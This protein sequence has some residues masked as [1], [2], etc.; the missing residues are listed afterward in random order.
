IENDRVIDHDDEINM[1]P[2]LTR[3]AVEYIDSQASNKKPFFL[4][5]PLGSPHN[6]IVP[7]PEWQ[8][9][10][11]LS[12]HA[13]FV[14]QT[15]HVVVA[16]SKA[17]DRQGLTDNT[18]VIFTSD[19]G[20]SRAAGID[21]LEAQGHFPSAHLRGSK[22]DLWDGGHRIPFIVRWP[23]QVEP[24]SQSDQLIC[25]T[26][27]LATSAEIIGES[28]PKGSGEDSVSFLPALGGKPIVSTRQGLIHHSSTGHFAY[29]HGKWKLLLARGSGGWSSPKENQVEP[30]ALEAQLYDMENDAGEK[31]NLYTKYPTVTQ[32]LL[33]LL[34]ADVN[35]GRST[36]GITSLND[37]T[38]IVLW[39]SGQG[40]AGP[41]KEKETR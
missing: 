15:D 20:T 1:L 18:L 8:G 31:N 27:L 41:K 16:V 11:N 5:V 35:A 9:K 22:A 38:D 25:L 21:K 34:A 37:V 3:K 32:R 29:R 4:Y 23:G 2:R 26:D 7:S 6:P 14:M 33:G 17:L 30:G 39:K 13:D 36:D 12:P 19:N 28:M 10:S 40:P 24:G